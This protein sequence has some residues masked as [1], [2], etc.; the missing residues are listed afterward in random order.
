MTRIPAREREQ[1]TADERALFDAIAGPRG[2]VV[3]GP[4]AIWMHT[5][6]I[7]GMANDL[8]NE[9]RVRGTLDKRLFELAILVVARDWT[10][11]YEWYVHAEASLKAGLA[12]GVVDAIRTGAT[13]VLEKEDEAIVYEACR[14]LM[15]ERRISE[16]LFARLIALLGRQQTIELITVIG[17]YTMVA[18]VLNAFEAPTPDGQRPLEPRKAH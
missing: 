16:P 3:R 18:V 9:L 8:G 17:F 15:T 10:A 12:P 1:L 6:S 4:F 5:P 2:G 7:A 14:E 13:P 11:Q